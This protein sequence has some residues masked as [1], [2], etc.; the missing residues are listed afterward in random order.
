MFII[1]SGY[2]G[3][4]CI[5]ITNKH[6]PLGQCIP[7]NSALCLCVGVRERKLW[8][9]HYLNLKRINPFFLSKLGEWGNT[10][11]QL[12]TWK[13]FIKSQKIKVG[14]LST[15][16]KNR[17]GRTFVLRCARSLLL[18]V[19]QSGEGPFTPIF[20]SLISTEVC[21]HM[22]MHKDVSSSHTCVEMNQRALHTW[23]CSL[24]PGTFHERAGVIHLWVLTLRHP[25]RI[26]F[27]GARSL[28]CLEVT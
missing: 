8:E 21:L 3:F 6:L 17:D 11:K 1:S 5:F 4:W 10:E 26:C 25:G 18:W 12:N 20:I 9:I 2:R 22:R 19:K 27:L 24:H 16:V 15:L 28:C 13:M 23:S 7:D 14:G